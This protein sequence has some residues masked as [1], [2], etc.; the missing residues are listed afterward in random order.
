[1]KQLIYLIL[2]VG[3]TS[4]DT[5][6]YKATISINAGKPGHPISSSSHGVFFAAISHG[7]EGGLHAE[8]IHNR[9]FKK[10]TL[11]YSVTLMNEGFWDI[12][13]VIHTDK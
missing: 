12:N 5:S 7:G 9:G 2:R 1:M 6:Q 13:I 4:T 10:S 8:L 11:P 3:F